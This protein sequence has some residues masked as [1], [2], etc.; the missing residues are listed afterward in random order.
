MRVRIAGARR[1]A[2][3]PRMPTLRTPARISGSRSI[4][5]LSSS[6]E[7]S[8]E[9]GEPQDV[10][11]VRRLIGLSVRN[12]IGQEQSHRHLTAK[13]IGQVLRFNGWDDVVVSAVKQEDRRRGFRR[14]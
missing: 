7:I 6:Q 14:S 3:H 2:G 13:A 10:W 4:G 11:D 8:P 12:Q 1:S 5:R 9:A